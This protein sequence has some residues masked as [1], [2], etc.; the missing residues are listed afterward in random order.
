MRKDDTPTEHSPSLYWKRGK[1]PM[2]M[3]GWRWYKASTGFWRPGSER[4]HGEKAWETQ[5]PHPD[6]CI[7]PPNTDQALLS[8]WGPA[9]GS[10]GSPR[11][12]MPA[13]PWGSPPDWTGSTQTW[14]WRGHQRS[15]A[16][17][18]WVWDSGQRTEKMTWSRS[19]SQKPRRDCKWKQDAFNRDAG[20][21]IPSLRW[22]I[23]KEKSH[24]FLLEWKWLDEELSPELLHQQDRKV[25]LWLT[26][27]F[28]SD[29]QTSSCST[30]IKVDTKNTRWTFCP[31][32]GRSRAQK[33]VCCSKWH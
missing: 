18:W 5:I 32:Q 1:S 4:R 21:F 16:P 13:A 20:G 27:R 30:N 15:A 31:A 2:N 6:T 22:R 33:S 3:S 28:A 7:C 23:Y 12:R 11:E 10:S 29:P 14:T 24:A 26:L 25:W 8:A 9:W 17:R 19:M